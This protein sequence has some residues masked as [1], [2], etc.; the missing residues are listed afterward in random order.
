MPRPGMGPLRAARRTDGTAALATGGGGEAADA[1]KPDRQKPPLT[2][3]SGGFAVLRIRRG[4]PAAT[5][6][7]EP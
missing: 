5:Y 3:V 6:S 7:P 1:A 4:G 2:F